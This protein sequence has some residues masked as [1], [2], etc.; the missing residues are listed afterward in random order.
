MKAL[1]ICL[2][3][4][5]LATALCLTSCQR[6]SS[7]PEDLRVPRLYVES[8]GMNY[9]AMTSMRL[10]LPQSGAEIEVNKEPFIN[11]FEIINA[12]MVKVDLGKALLLQLTDAGARALYRK[13]VTNLGSRIV[14]TIN[15]NPAGVRRLDGA[16]AD[17]N[18]FTFVELD[19]K[20]LEELVTALKLSLKYLQAESSQSW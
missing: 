15:N 14:L 6:K 5:F 1:S 7:P 20:E 18:Y 12:E 2:K 16:I 10:K 9:G 19:T 17:G 4:F 11:E 13:S 3:V 8:R